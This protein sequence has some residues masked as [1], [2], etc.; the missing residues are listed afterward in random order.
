VD[1]SAATIHHFRRQLRNIEWALGTLDTRN[2]EHIT[3][4]RKLANDHAVYREAL[5]EHGVIH[6]APVVHW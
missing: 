5:R 3:Q 4:V 2:P 6:P 1:E